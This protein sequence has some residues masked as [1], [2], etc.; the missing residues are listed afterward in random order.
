MSQNFSDYT[1]QLKGLFAH[2]AWAHVLP[3]LFIGILTQAFVVA[4]VHWSTTFLGEHSRTFYT[5]AL[6]AC[7]PFFTLGF[8]AAFVRLHHRTLTALERG[9]VVALCSLLALVGAGCIALVFKLSEAAAEVFAHA[10][11]GDQAPQLP[12][13]LER[14]SDWW[15]LLAVPIAAVVGYFTA[16]PAVQTECQRILPTKTKR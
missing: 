13:V 4:I 5:V 7:A 14:S 1:K 8:N 16:L 11:A 12:V 9:W 6:V 3:P 10:V 2:G 15:L